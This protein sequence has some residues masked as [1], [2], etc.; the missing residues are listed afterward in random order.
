[1]HCYRLF[2]VA[3]SGMNSQAQPLTIAELEVCHQFVTNV[4]L[5]VTNVALIAFSKRYL[6]FKLLVLGL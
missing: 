3:E 1:M 4:A 6:T 5:F 2:P